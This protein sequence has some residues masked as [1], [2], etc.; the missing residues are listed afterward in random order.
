VNASKPD[1]NTLNICYNMLL[2]SC[3]KVTSFTVHIA[4]WYVS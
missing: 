1:T 4:E 2:N 3:Q